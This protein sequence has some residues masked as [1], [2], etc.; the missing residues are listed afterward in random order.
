MEMWSLS[1]LCF[2]LLSFGNATI[3]EGTSQP[4]ETSTLAIFR[5]N[6]LSS[7]VKNVIASPDLPALPDLPVYNKSRGLE[8]CREDYAQAGKP[9]I[10]LT[11][12]V[13]IGRS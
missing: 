8:S 9:N 11:Y 4:E 5:R 10:F 2:L 12:S 6:G 13:N 1:T 7:S 3:Q